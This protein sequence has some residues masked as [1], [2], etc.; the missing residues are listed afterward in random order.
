MTGRCIIVGASHAGVTCALSLRRFGWRGEITLFGDETTL[1]YHRPPLTKDYLKCSKN[2]DSILLHSLERYVKAGIELNLGQRVV[3]VDR[4]SQSVITDVGNQSRYDKLVL[5]TG[6]SAI[7]LPFVRSDLQGVCYLRSLTDV[8][9]IRG[10]AKADKR[11]V[12][13]GGGYIGL[14]AAAS[15][16]AMGM[17][18][19]V[20]EAA[21]RI[22]ERVTSDAVSRFFSRIHREE[23]VEIYER[24]QVSEILGQEAVEGVL[25]ASGERMRADLVVIG[26]GVRPNVELGQSAGLKIDNGICV[27]TYTQTEDPNI[28]AIGDCAN[29]L[30]QRYRRQI[31]LESIQNANDQALVAAKAI[32]GKPQPYGAVPWFWSDQYDVKLQIA[33]LADGF[34]NVVVR[35]DPGSGRTMSVVYLKDHQLLAVDALN[36]P[37]DFVQ[38]KKLIQSEAT[39]DTEILADSTSTLL[40]AEVT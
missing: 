25:L 39:L 26:I 24:C 30:H 20:V 13:I 37:R 38:G 28:F 34:D 36:R 14:E 35:R 8:D 1:P 29:V 15:L 11:A 16:R 6:A 12:I 9:R 10:H 5:A 4:S 31:R 23:G 22:L 32:S 40:D 21:D 17:R 19:A 33:G 27:D 3:R 7:Q 18:V 2:G